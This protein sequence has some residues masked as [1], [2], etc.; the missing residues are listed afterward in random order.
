MR[1]YKDNRSQ[2]DHQHHGLLVSSH[3][4]TVTITRVGDISMSSD[5]LKS[6]TCVILKY[7]G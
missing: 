5:V 1:A 4:H 6:D 2:H 7:E 3:D